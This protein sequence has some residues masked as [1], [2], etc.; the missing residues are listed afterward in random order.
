[1]EYFFGIDFGACNLKC[2]R[3]DDLKLRAVKLNTNDDGSFHTPSAIFYNRTKSG[4]VDKIIGQTALNQ[5]ALD[6]ENLIVDLKR[7][8]EI[9]DWRKNIPALSREVTA[10]EVAEDIF[11]KIYAFAA[12]N[13]QPDDTAR[14][15]I[16]VPAI[17]TERQR[18]ILADAATRAS[19][20]VDAVVNEAFAAIFGVQ[21]EE[22]S[23]NVIFDF[24]GSTLDV[25]VIKFGG[26]EVT[27]LVA[28]GLNLGGLDIDRDILE[29]ILRPKFAEEL[30][31]AWDVENSGDLQLNFARRLKETLYGDFE[32]SVDAELVE[33]RPGFDKI[34]LNR[35][36]VNELLEREGY[37]DKITALLDEIFD[38]LEQG[39]D[40]FDR[41]DVTAIWAFGGSMHIPYFR[42]LL[43]NYFGAEIFDADGYEFD[44]DEGLAAGLEDK[45]LVVAGGAANFLKQREKIRTVNV[46][47][48]QICYSLGGSLKPGIA[49]NS[50][51]GFETLYLKL[52]PAELEK[53]GWK[54]E[55]YQAFANLSDA[56]YLGEIKL[57]P[58]LYEKSEPPLLKLKILRDGKLR[59]RIFERR[60]AEIALVEEF[61]I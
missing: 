4:G 35:A 1:M 55:L 9:K 36:E 7:K 40:C 46:I 10:P 13:F 38:E 27:E 37:G 26:G 61:E 47:P 11:K 44:D 12:R 15:A 31:A 6:S 23:L 3:A 57:N 48:C 58:A 19:F 51:H 33:F 22:D 20:T 60:A 52:N 42:N 43:E 41:E 45:Y 17:F 2:V 5:G 30:D 8:L 28:S 29:K 21:A 39:A 53:F 54:I 50:A 18:R 32:E 24:G 49:K 25:S 34:S 56:A 14:A 16:T 59:L